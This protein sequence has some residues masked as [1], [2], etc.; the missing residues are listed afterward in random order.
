MLLS[1]ESEEDI[2]AIIK[3]DGNRRLAE[4]IITFRRAQEE[5]QRLKDRKKGYIKDS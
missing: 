1:S 2:R 4:K 3:R 5:R